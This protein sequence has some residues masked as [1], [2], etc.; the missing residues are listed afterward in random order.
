MDALLKNHCENTLTDAFLVIGLGGPR[1]LKWSDTPHPIEM[2][3]KWIFYRLAVQDW[4]VTAAKQATPKPLPARE[5]D[6]TIWAKSADDHFSERGG[7]DHMALWEVAQGLA[8]GW[9]E[10]DRKRIG[11]VVEACKRFMLLI[12]EQDL[13]LRHPS[14][15][16]PKLELCDMLKRARVSRFEHT[17]GKPGRPLN[18]KRP[19]ASNVSYALKVTELVRE[20]QGQNQA[21][22]QALSGLHGDH[23]YKST[24]QSVLRILNRGAE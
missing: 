22:R 11:A 6:M 17:T 16:D 14:A 18:S 20:G 12:P 9:I 10:G 23:A 13:V 2:S 24:R 21:L 4:Q 15:I 1:P 5:W 3:V 7:V 8:C 19:K